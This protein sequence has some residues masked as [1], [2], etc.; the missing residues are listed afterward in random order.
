MTLRDTGVR[1]EHGMEP[2]DDIFSSPGKADSD[3]GDEDEDEDDE[4]EEE[5]E[6]EEADDNEDEDSGDVPM[7][8]T[9]GM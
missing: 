6:E 3:D 1:D 9:T 2:I 5:E 8:L 7:D 4:E